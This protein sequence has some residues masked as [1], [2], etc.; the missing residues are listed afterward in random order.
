M[1]VLVLQTLY[2][3]QFKAEERYSKPNSA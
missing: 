2:L 3:V 1:G